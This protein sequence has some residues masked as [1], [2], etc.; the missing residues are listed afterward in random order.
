MKPMRFCALT[1]VA[2]LGLAGCDNKPVNTGPGTGA[3]ATTP[4]KDSGT[5]KKDHEHGAGPHGG[6]IGEFGGKYHFEFTVSHPKQ[7]AIVYILGGDAVKPAPIKAETLTLSIF[8]PP[9]RVEFKPAPQPGDPPGT[10]SRFVGKHEKLGVEQE[11][12]GE[13]SGDVDGK[14]LAGEFEEKPEKK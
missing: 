14:P 3:N 10:S 8:K 4:A 1:V 9:F 2:A 7:E 6:A 12:T 13:L 5:G 11:F